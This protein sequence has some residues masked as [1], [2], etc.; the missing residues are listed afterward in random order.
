[1]NNVNAYGYNNQVSAL[2]KYNS[3]AMKIQKKDNSPISVIDPA[4]LSANQQSTLDK[5]KEKYADMDFY[6]VDSVDDDNAERVMAS[7][8]KDYSVVMTKDELEKMASDEDYL[9]KRMSDLD[10]FIALAEKLKNQYNGEKD[11]EEG[12]TEGSKI[13]K[14]GA[15]FNSDGTTTYFAELEKLSA[16]QKERIEERREKKAE[17]KKAEEKKESK[18]A[19][20]VSDKKPAKVEKTEIKA[21]SV[22]ELMKKLGDYFQDEKMGNVRTK[23][24][25]MVGQ[26]FDFSL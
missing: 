3:G 12:S 20:D 6:V 15:V 21:D 10:D 22:E 1:M 17:E 2:E 9:N 23:E 26:N 11:A 4:S 25:M 19:I 16:K 7:G 8:T 24:E 13:T 18:D 14:F 5:L